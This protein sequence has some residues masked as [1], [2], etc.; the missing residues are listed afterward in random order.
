MILIQV[1]RE[2]GGR[3]ERERERERER[4]ERERERERFIC[5]YTLSATG[6]LHKHDNQHEWN[7]WSA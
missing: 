4:G 7:F 6:N 3:E 2:E 1:G 5:N